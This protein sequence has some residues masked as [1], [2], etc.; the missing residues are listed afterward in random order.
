M[1]QT[2]RKLMIMYNIFQ[3]YVSRREGGRG[4]SSIEDSVDTS[5]RL[6]DFIEKPGRRLIA[7]SGNNTND[8]RTRGTTITRKQK[9]EGK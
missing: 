2:T 4:L 6:E 9:S 1:N 8:T 5:I 3:L 7:G